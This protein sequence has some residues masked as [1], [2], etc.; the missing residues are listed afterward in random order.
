MAVTQ[1]RRGSDTADAAISTISTTARPGAGPQYAARGMVASASPA[2]AATG[3]RVLM[4]GGNA[5]DAAVAVAM[6]EGL[7]LPGACGLGGDMFAVLYDARQRRVWAINGSGAAPQ[8]VTRDYYVSRGHQTMPLDGIHSVSVPGAPHAYWTLHQ[9]F[10]TRPWA[11]LL[12]PAIALAEHGVAVSER[13][14]RSIAGARR[15]LE[16]FASSAAEF[17]PDGE[18][19]RAGT[20]FQRARYAQ[21]LRLL[22]EGGADAFYRGPIAAEIVRYARE[23]GGLFDETDFAQ[24]ATEVYEPIHT[25]YRGV[26]VYET[27]PPSQGLIVLEWLNLLEGF[28]LAASGFGTAETIHLMAEAKKLAFADR[29]RYAGDPRFIDV[30]LAALLSKPFAARRRQEIDP[31]RAAWPVRGALPETLYGDTSYFCVAD[32]EGNAISFIHSLSAG[33]GS[34]VTAGSTGILLNNRAG[35]GFTLEEGHPNVLAG[36]KKTM[37]TL[38]CYLLMREGA[39]LGV[40]GTPGGDQQPQWNV[41]TITNLLDFGL[42]VQQAI[43]APRW[44]SFPGTDPEHIAKPPELRLEARFDPSVAPALEARGHRVVLLG[45][46]GAGGAVQLIVRRPNGVLVGGSDPRAGGVALG[47]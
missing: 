26:E 32:G 47:Y 15:K 28:D 24:H 40:G 36:G 4:D 39:L 44:Y 20:L 18:T 38:N 13:M 5:F 19:P 42:D 23:L 14:A 8:R 3:L 41:Q 17:F 27:R 7:T 43:E 12:A 45:P 25:T 21:S 2:A 37:H 11:D 31:H 22:A 34:G 33:F 10:G 16:Q 35:R 29:L 30:P 46:W 6:V 9:R 1:A